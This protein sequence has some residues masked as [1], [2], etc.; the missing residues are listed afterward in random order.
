[1]FRE[2]PVVTECQP[3]FA[4]AMAGHL[5]GD[6]LAVTVLE[7]GTVFRHTLFVAQLGQPRIVAVT[8]AGFTRAAAFTVAVVLFL[9]VRLDAGGSA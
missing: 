9:F 2:A 3:L 7:A 4:L 8:F 6:T 1:M 5:A